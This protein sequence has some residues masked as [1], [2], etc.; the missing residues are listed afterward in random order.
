MYRYRNVPVNTANTWL[1]THHS[2]PLDDGEQSRPRSLDENAILKKAAREGQGFRQ[3][4]AGY[5]IDDFD[6]TQGSVMMAR[7]KRFGRVS[8]FDYFE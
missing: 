7:C 6:T 8:I 4:A 3:Y 1:A 5:E 2:S